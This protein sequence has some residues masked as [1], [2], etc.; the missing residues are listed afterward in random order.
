MNI[1]KKSPVRKAIY[2]VLFLA[3]I[4]AFIY[5]SEK[6]KSNADDPVRII[7]NYYDMDLENDF[8]PVITGGQFI[9][10]I[11]KGKSIIL[12]GSKT[13]SWSKE[14]VKQV[15]EDVKDLGV[16]KI[17]YY[18]INNDK[19]QK[20]SNYYRIKELLEGSLTTT[21][22]SKS[23]LLAPS[24]YI[25]VDG[26]VKYYNVDTVAMK[27]TLKVEDYWNDFKKQEFKEELVNAIKKYY[28]NN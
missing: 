21:D 15:N 11:Q 10:L 9:N 4:G 6:Y 20:K 3:M 16:D 5:L 28:L 2:A 17:Y 19:A 25:I 18:D 12:V 22:G 7:T 24:I 13:S 23:N 1:N 14:F 8:Y 26:E 27:N